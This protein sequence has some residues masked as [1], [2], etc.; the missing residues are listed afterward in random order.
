M[1]DFELPV[2]EKLKVN[3]DFEIPKVPEPSPESDFEIQAQQIIDRSPDPVKTQKILEQAAAI[4]GV[5]HLPWDDAFNKATTLTTTKSP[6]PKKL[7]Q[8]IADR[9][10]AEQLTIRIGQVG[11]DVRKAYRRGDTA[12]IE[13]LTKGYDALTAQLPAFED[14]ASA[15]P[16]N[17]L[18]K[19][20]GFGRRMLTGGV[21][22]VG[23]Q[24]E[25]IAGERQRERMAEFA[26]EEALSPA[27]LKF[28][29]GESLQFLKG[30]G[31][32]EAGAA[33]M[34]MVKAGVDPGIAD[35]FAKGIGVINNILE[36]AEFATFVKMFPGAEAVV[37]KATSGLMKKVILGPVLKNTAL[38]LTAKLAMGTAQQLAQ[39]V[40]Q[41]AVTFYG[42]N[43]AIE[44]NNAT[45][46]TALEGN[47][48]FADRAKQII[49][50]FL[51]GVLALGAIP[52]GM[53]A[54]KKGE[55]VKATA[56]PAAAPTPIETV[57]ADVAKA[58]ETATPEVA[59]AALD[60]AETAKAAEI[61][62]AEILTPQMVW[63]AVELVNMQETVE[64]QAQTVE[65]SE[66]PIAGPSTPT[67][68]TE[69]RASV[70]SGRWVDDIT[71]SHFHEEGWTKS[72]IARRED[73]REL[74]S[75]L[76]NTGLATSFD[77]FVAA[78]KEIEVTPQSTEYYQGIWDTAAKKEVEVDEEQ[79]IDTEARIDA[80]ITAEEKQAQKIPVTDRLLGELEK[81]PMWRPDLEKV[82]DALAAKEIPETTIEGE[83]LNA[84]QMSN[85]LARNKKRL[86]Q[87]MTH[88]FLKP[89]S[90]GIGPV[91]I[92][93]IRILQEN[94]TTKETKSL[95]KAKEALTTWK[96]AHPGQI[97]IPEAQTI[98]DQQGIKD[99][100]ISQLIDLYKQSREIR[101]KGVA[102]HRAW[103]EGVKV[104]RVQ[105]A[106][107]L[108]AEIPGGVTA[109]RLAEFASE[110]TQKQE[111][112]L[113]RKGKLKA[114][115]MHPLRLF[116]KMGP[117]AEKYFWDMRKKWEG[118]A[119]VLSQGK[120]KAIAE[121]LKKGGLT[122]TEMLRKLPETDYYIDDLMTYYGQMQDS[123]GRKAILWGNDEDETKITRLLGEL[124][125]KYKDFADGVI[126]INS[127]TYPE[128][129]RTQIENTGTTAPAVKRYLPLRRE[130]DYGKP[131]AQELSMQ[132]AVR[133]SARLSG[134]QKGFTNQRVTFK[135]GTQQ[136]RFRTDFLNIL[137]EQID[138]ESAYVAGEEWARDMS[139]LL[140]GKAKESKQFLEATKQ[141][142]GQPVVTFLKDYANAVV[143]PESFNGTNFQGLI[144]RVFRNTSDAVLMYKL[145]TAFI[146]IEGPFR[147]LSQLDA[148]QWPYLFAGLWKASAHPIES[149]KF[150][151]E[152]SPVMQIMA[153][154]KAIDPAIQESRGLKHSR[155]EIALKLQMTHK[156]MRHGG[157]WMLTKMNKWTIISE[158]TSIYFA[159]R[160]KLGE[161]AAIK[162]ADDGVFL[163]QPSGTLADAPRM[164]WTSKK[165]IILAFLARFSRASNQMAQMMS[166]DLWNDLKTG[167]PA[168]ALGV[169]MSF[170]IGAALMGLRRR[171]RFPKNAEELRDDAIAGATDA[172]GAVTFG[173]GPA[174][175]AGATRGFRAGEIKPLE[176][177]Y[178]AGAIGKDI[179]YGNVSEKEVW[180]LINTVMQ[181]T[182]LPAPAA[183]NL[184]RAAYDFEEMGFRFDPIELFGRRPRGE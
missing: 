72:E 152:K 54:M 23:Q 97:F 130:G 180:R 92:N 121:L 119:S 34:D 156:G 128:V 123:N 16:D 120:S 176:P 19:A 69:V 5:T 148:K 57:R 125:Q 117:A 173:A 107:D 106:T 110:K 28:A 183:E 41:E 12:E 71:L 8:A 136:A 63:E 109:K 122:T 177:F 35:R 170:A 59:R 37:S 75:Y 93:Q 17:I 66:Q 11:N 49:Y 181:A 27:Y 184:I 24:V 169:V 137:T 153:E 68:L 46:G 163:N 139:W 64:E 133:E 132:A 56:K 150:V 33:F 168:K 140:G 87:R 51:P 115:I 116:K 179:F 161:E 147:T 78:A 52:I 2:I 31:E 131:F 14:V 79:T 102:E 127:K 1:S 164:Y 3:P 113:A 84:A 65:V 89:P 114:N 45:R 142:Y 108:F 26:P 151:Y 80:T 85:E 129:E 6:Y 10:K 141:K 165:N 9:W 61:A 104:R 43:W 77:A 95:R 29:V 86:I 174:V 138:A 143:N 160:V 145:S 81:T 134:L 149:A 32:V 98:M 21:G 83:E 70:E 13:R 53:Q 38:Q 62:Q 167:H 36:F 159:N 162:A 40:A 25:L 88:D 146:Q 157:Y 101:K 100:P 74:A 94:Y 50:D 166:V 178:A 39:E 18:G 182:G 48:D 124:P 144:S 67:V 175:V 158:W 55:V 112:R 105:M 7:G 103:R 118:K 76:A 30:I 22:L 111:R 171:K 99:L 82:S 42:E 90:A 172:L 60:V 4:H 154:G 47:K 20:I 155:S 15:Y 126:E 73:L 44:I 58:L 96:T 135:E 91:A